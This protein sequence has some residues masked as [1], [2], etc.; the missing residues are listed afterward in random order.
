[1][2]E[3]AADTTDYKEAMY[4]KAVVLADLIEHE[5]DNDIIGMTVKL[6][7]IDYLQFCKQVGLNPVNPMNIPG[8]D[9]LAGMAPDGGV[10]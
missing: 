5:A 1:M 10:N 3:E 4:Q 6:L 2:T 9:G 7:A 8:Q